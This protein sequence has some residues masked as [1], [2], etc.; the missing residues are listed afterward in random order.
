MQYFKDGTEC[1]DD[2]YPC[3][4]NQKK[5]KLGSRTCIQLEKLFIYLYN[6]TI[7]NKIPFIK[8]EGEIY[9]S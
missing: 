3:T 9:L 4:N 1:F 7:R 2:Y 5:K 6:T 8:G